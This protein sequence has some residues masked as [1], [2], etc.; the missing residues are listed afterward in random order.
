MKFIA[1]TSAGGRSS[2]DG[3]E[4]E[5][6]GESITF[7][8]NAK[9]GLRNWVNLDT[10]FDAV[11]ALF[12][13]LNEEEQEEMYWQYRKLHDLAIFKQ[14]N[15]ESLHEDLEN[16]MIAI[17]T[18]LPIE[19]IIEWSGNAYDGYA[20]PDTIGQISEGNYPTESSYK[21]WEYLELCGLSTVFKLS[22]PLVGSFISDYK[23]IHSNP[24][25]ANEFKEYN[26]IQ[27]YRN[28]K[29][30][31]CR[32][33]QKLRAQ[34]LGRVST[35]AEGVK[36]PM[37]LLEAGIG[38]EDY[39]LFYLANDLLRTLCLSETDIK[40]RDGGEPNNITA[41]LT[42]SL[43][44]RQG[45]IDKKFN[46][47]NSMTPKE[48][49]GEDGGNTSIQEDIHAIERFSSLYGRYFTQAYGNDKLYERFKIEPELFETFRKHI[50]M[51][52]PTTTQG[53]CIII[54]L[55]FTDFAGVESLN[56]IPKDI[57]VRVMAITAAYIHKLKLYNLVNYLLAVEDLESTSAD[58]RQNIADQAKPSQSIRERFRMFY[59]TNNAGTNYG[60]IYIKE[61]VKEEVC[62][63]RW[64]LFSPTSLNEAGAEYYGINEQ[65]AGDRN[66]K[67]HLM[68]LIIAIEE[69]MLAQNH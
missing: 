23:A 58:I 60:E 32:P 27:L 18:L 33:Y 4:V 16:I 3:I 15:F 38:T 1:K 26:I 36:V 49:S 51:Y 30:E 45:H 22:L 35:A 65:W 57:L 47:P 44:Q 42:N 66:F 54:G 53:K 67:D 39:P 19:G 68:M 52:P 25:T 62:A 48:K 59:P 21:P 37:G 2:L 11:N 20:I 9:H 29:L 14:G 69:N 5:H 46:Y 41:K 61:F 34:V 64:R 56:L 12:R 50:E 40:Y 8:L 7:A 28:V 63:K 6:A 31:D 17:H 24:K 13:N 10:L 43:R 55:V